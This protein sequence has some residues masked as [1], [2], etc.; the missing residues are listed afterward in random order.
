MRCF[1]VVHTQTAALGFCRVAGEFC[2][3]HLQEAAA[4]NQHAA[5]GTTGFVVRKGC[6]FTVRIGHVAGVIAAAAFIRVVILKYDAVHR[7]FAVQGVY[8]AAAFI[9]GSIA[10]DN[11]AEE[12]NLCPVVSERSAVLRFTL[13]PIEQN[14]A[15]A[16]L[17]VFAF[18]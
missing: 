6:V 14:A 8:A 7:N 11:A 17:I 13:F 5:A 1:D 16:T 2:I 3:I 10:A 9:L 4:V 15:A 12:L 18:S